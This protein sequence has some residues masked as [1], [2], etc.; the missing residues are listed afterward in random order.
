[1]STVFHYNYSAQQNK[2]VQS[3]RDK[4]L[5]KQE[6]GLDELRRL[7]RQVSNAGF[8]P[9]LVVGVLSCLVFGLGMCFA[10]GALPKSMVLGV[11]FG[12]IGSAGMA[13]AYPLYR[14]RFQKTKERLQ[15]RILS[16]AAELCGETAIPEN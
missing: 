9:G 1:M 4:Y 15:P 5:P 7:D 8:V 14:Y 12:V 11:L 3:I 10:M 6:T 2:E 16:L 13:M